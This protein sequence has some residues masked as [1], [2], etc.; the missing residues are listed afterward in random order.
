MRM[1]GWT[2]EAVPRVR[3]WMQSPV[4]AVLLLGAVATGMVLISTE[5]YLID[6]ERNELRHAGEE[7]ASIERADVLAR[8]RALHEQAIAACSGEAIEAIARGR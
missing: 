8:V 1:V 6:L 4:R 7:A 5:L 2:M 3:R